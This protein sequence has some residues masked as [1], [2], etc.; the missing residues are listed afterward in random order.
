MKVAL[1]VVAMARIAPPMM[2]KLSAAGVRNA[3]A[4]SIR[5]LSAQASH[6]VTPTATK[7]MAM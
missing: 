1:S 3:R 4:D 6:P 5:D 2:K 7:L